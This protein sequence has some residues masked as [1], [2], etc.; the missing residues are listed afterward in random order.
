MKK[1]K[2]RRGDTVRIV[3]GKD[4][5]ARNAE[6]RVVRVI[7]EKNLV[8]VEGLNIAKK[9]QK[10]SGNVLQGGRIDR[11]MPVHISNVMLVC[12]SCGPT[13]AGF[14]FTE[15]GKVRVCKKCGDEL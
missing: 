6:G 5:T 7:P 14:E 10:P 2:I 13:R 3:A 12:K 11:E 1:L 4:R 15:V 8:V 9:H